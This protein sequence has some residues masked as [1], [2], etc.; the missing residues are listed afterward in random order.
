MQTHGP[1][2][3]YPTERD[4]PKDT[5]PKTGGYDRPG[6]GKDDPKDTGPKTG[7]YDQPGR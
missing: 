6:K 7:G 5:G 4:D 1:L 3:V 2:G